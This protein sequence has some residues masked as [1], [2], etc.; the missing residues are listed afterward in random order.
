MFYKFF[1]CNCLAL[2]IVIIQTLKHVWKLMQ[3]WIINLF[4]YY[5]AKFE[6]L[7]YKALLLDHRILI[8]FYWILSGHT[9]KPLKKH[10]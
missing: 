2:L 5:T 8:Q 7:H 10:Q 3:L 9:R 4:T 1:D 6:R